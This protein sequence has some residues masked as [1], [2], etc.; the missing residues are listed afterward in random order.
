MVC[1]CGGGGE[2]ELKTISWLMGVGARG[3]VPPDP[4]GNI[5]MAAVPGAMRPSIIDDTVEFNPPYIVA[6][7]SFKGQNPDDKLHI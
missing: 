6:P 4:Q 3:D 7:L 5:S 2:V 1:V